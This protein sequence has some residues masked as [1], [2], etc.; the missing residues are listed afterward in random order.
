[1]PFL[2]LTVIIRIPLRYLILLVFFLF[3]ACQP[4]TKAPQLPMEQSAHSNLEEEQ[5]LNQILL[6]FIDDQKAELWSAAPSP[7][8]I[9]TSKIDL[10]YS[11]PGIF[12]SLDQLAP[13]TLSNLNHELIDLKN[14]RKVII[15]PNDARQ[16]GQFR[17]CFACPLGTTT[18]YASLEMHLKAFPFPK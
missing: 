15:F 1:M 10:K 14:I 17:P 8:L 11:E 7:V 2:V 18:L 12:E 16:N 4:D 5:T 13:A 9:Q 6:L 3:S